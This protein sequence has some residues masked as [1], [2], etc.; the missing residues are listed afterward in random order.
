[1]LEIYPKEKPNKI[2]T[3]SAPKLKNGKCQKENVTKKSTIKPINFNRQKFINE[4]TIFQME[5]PKQKEIIYST[6][7]TPLWG[8]KKINK[9]L[10]IIAQKTKNDRK[11]CARYKCARKRKFYTQKCN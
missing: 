5:P 7:D 1:M 8:P 6:R 2:E 11:S 4:Q 10:L 9:I 3:K